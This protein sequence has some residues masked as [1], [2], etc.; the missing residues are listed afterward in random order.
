MSKHQ[1]SLIALAFII[2][3]LPAAAAR[4]VD[5]RVQLDGATA[6]RRAFVLRVNALFRRLPADPINLDRGGGVTFDIFRS[7]NAGVFCDFFEK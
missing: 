4:P 6:I 5:S 3:V 2:I 1:L 7:I